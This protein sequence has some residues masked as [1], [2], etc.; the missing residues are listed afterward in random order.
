MFRADDSLSERWL[1]H[2]FLVSFNINKLLE[3]ISY[4][5]SMAHTITFTIIMKI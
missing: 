4:N 2:G 1:S 3:S 5:N